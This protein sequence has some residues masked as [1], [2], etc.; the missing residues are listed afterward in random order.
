MRPINRSRE[1]NH[2]G[3]ETFSVSE[4]NQFKKNFKKKKIKA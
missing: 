3:H 1:E 2:R 4:K